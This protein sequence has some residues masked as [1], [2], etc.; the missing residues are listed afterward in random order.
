MKLA[1]IDECTGCG[2]CASVCMKKC[3]QMKIGDNGFYYPQVDTDSCID[4]GLCASNCH[5]LSFP[6]FNSFEKN[7]YLGWDLLESKRFEASSGGAFGAIAELVISE[8]GVVYGAAFSA[9]KKTLSHCS[10][11]EVSLSML[12]KSKYLES[13]MGETIRDIRNELKAGKTVL[14]CGTPCQVYGVRK[15]LGKEN[16]KLLLCDFLCH[17]VPSQVRYQQYINELELKFKSSVKNIGFRTKRFGWKT[18]CIVVDFENG[19]QYVKLANEDPYYKHFF[20]NT[21]IRSSCYN[22][23]RVLKSAADITLGD[24]W[25][26]KRCGYSDDDKGISLIVCNTEFGKYIISKLQ[27]FK[28]CQISD[29]EAAYAFR[30][31]RIEKKLTPI[32]QPFFDS[33]TISLKEK[34]VCTALRYN[35]LRRIIYFIINISVK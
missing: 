2:A 14:F 5:V 11:K 3:I 35:F 25:A 32:N 34:L 18:Y 31:R 22:C 6:F 1:T 21:N 17:G 8:G 13:N 33:F 15:V 28:R 26:A 16:K 29:V 19:K 20:S 24:F 4:C 27:S 23:N 7:Y 10:T 9:D 30:E 12:K